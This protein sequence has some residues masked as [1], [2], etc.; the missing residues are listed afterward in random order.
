MTLDLQKVNE[1]KQAVLR[2][3]RSAHV[4]HQQNALGL[5][6]RLIL[7]AATASSKR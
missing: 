5:R 4:R 3:T 1:V 7:H 2:S 6:N